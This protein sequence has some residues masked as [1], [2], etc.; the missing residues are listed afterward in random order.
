MSPSAGPEYKYNI[1]DFTNNFSFANYVL[2]DKM[3]T[4]MRKRVTEY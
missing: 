3:K 2:L 1:F 4:R